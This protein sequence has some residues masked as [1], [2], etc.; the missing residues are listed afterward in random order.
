MR[1]KLIAI[2]S[3]VVLVTGLLAFVLMR[4]ALGDVLAGPDRARAE[5]DRAAASANAQLQLE[6]LNMQRWLTEQ[7]LNPQV[8]EP[9]LAD[10]PPARSEFATSQSNNLFSKATA[11]FPGA[12]P[13][14]VVFVDDK[15]IALGRNGS[16]LMRG[17]SL[18]KIYPSLADTIKAGI[19]GSD[20]WVN[21]ARN[22][23][24]LVSY[25]TVRDASGKVLGAVILGSALDD[26]RL[27]A[28]SELT[29][30]RP[31][32]LAVVAG[33]AVEVVA[34]SS[35]SPPAALTAISSASFKNAVVGALATPRPREMQNGP[36]GYAVSGCGLGGYGDGKRAAL[37]AFSHVSLVE[38]VT[39]LLW[40]IL[41]ATALGLVLVALAGTLLASY[42]TR[43]IVQL[44]EGLLTIING[45]TSQR[46]EIEHAEFGGLISRINSLLDALM[47]VPED[48]TDSEG[49]PSI[50]PSAN[51]FREALS[52]EGGGDKI[53]RSTA[54]A[55]RAEPADAYYQRLYDEYIQAKRSIG[56]PVDHI[57]KDMFTQ[58]IQG[59][60]K[61]TSERQ[62]KPVRFRVELQGR[63]VKLI[64]VPLE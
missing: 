43:P 49:R 15:G 25:A 57:T 44:E 12:N 60:E 18:G 61:D 56:D 50:A 8:R 47:G 62:G 31:V 28:V 46:F 13:S 52:V 16:P 5:A 38:S 11:A 45:Q 26:G 36:E 17:E 53:D 2:F 20:V 4:A 37:I 30:G 40:P 51:A 32:A 58:R 6:G 42:I 34:K 27:S 19:S 3:V 35:A 9:F 64:A 33:D 54:Q 23:Q 55:L 1:G 14:L 48:N 63:E 39:A 21:H 7:A 29:S 22:E 59:N 41:G 24:L 10:T